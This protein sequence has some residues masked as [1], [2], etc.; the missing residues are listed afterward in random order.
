M[1]NCNLEHFYSNRHMYV[2]IGMYA[3][4][5][6]I[7]VFCNNDV[8][9]FSFNFSLSLYVCCRWMYVYMGQLRHV[10]TLMFSE[11]TLSVCD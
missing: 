3:Y 10:V 8:H 7:I 4:A 5:A 1:K 11:Q 9:L 2:D 6:S